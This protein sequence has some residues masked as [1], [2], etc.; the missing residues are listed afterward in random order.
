[1]LESVDNRQAGTY[2][3]VA[4]NGVGE[5][6]SADATL[7]VYQDGEGKLPFIQ[8]QHTAET[9]IVYIVV[10]SQIPKIDSNF[11]NWICPLMTSSVSES[12]LSIELV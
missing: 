1:M 5:P 3:C 4:D 9:S 6:A 7:S 2:R 8:Y 12:C 10:I 11:K